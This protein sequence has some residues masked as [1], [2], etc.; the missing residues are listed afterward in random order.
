MWLVYVAALVIGLGVLLLQAVLGSHGGA[1]HHEIGAAP[2][3]D[4]HGD[5]GVGGFVGALLSLRFW[6]FASLAFG[7]SGSLIHAF[8]LAGPVATF[9]IA[10]GAGL[11]SGA[12]AVAV[13]RALTRGAAA[14]TPLT[15]S[16][17]GQ[18]AK[19]LVP[20][21]K[22]QVGQVRVALGNLTQGSGPQ[23]RDGMPKLPVGQREVR[24]WPVLD[25]GDAARHVD[26]RNGDV[27][28]RPPR[29][30]ARRAG[31]GRWRVAQPHVGGRRRQ[32]RIRQMGEAEGGQS[33]SQCFPRRSALGI[34][35]NRFA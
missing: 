31:D 9:L 26:P 29:H 23:N 22:G 16:A 24:N 25:L 8:A 27:V 1:E 30:R 20:L 19:V 6:I 3:H 7:L 34:R 28:A 14:P 17:V 12:F 11:A 10:L 2:G 4:D 35:F 13:F 18:I 33:G 5:S 21:E 15:S 32:V